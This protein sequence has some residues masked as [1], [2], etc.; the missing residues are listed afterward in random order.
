MLEFSSPVIDRIPFHSLDVGALDHFDNHLRVIFTSF[1]D[2]TE[3]L[4]MEIAAFG[5][6]AARS[7]WRPSGV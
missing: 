1:I 3:Y 6:G 2:S 4:W 7:S 5:D